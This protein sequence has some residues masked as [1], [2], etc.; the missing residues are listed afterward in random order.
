MATLAVEWGWGRP[1]QDP[2]VVTA[3]GWDSVK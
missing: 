2:M 3:M 1:L